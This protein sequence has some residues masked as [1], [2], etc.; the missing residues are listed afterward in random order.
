[1]IVSINYNYGIFVI[2]IVFFISPV[3]ITVN[4]N[5]HRRNYEF[6]KILRKY[7]TWHAN[8]CYA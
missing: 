3:T 1:M 6:T 4:N 2:N 8:D 7:Y 5:I